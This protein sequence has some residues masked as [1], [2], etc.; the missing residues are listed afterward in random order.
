MEIKGFQEN[1]L[2]EWEG[3]LSCVLFL[4]YCNLR[5]RYCHAAHL[6]DPGEN[7]SIEREKILA[8][9]RRQEGWLDGAA[10][11]GGEPTLHGDE[12]RELIRQIR[13]TGLKVMLETNGSDPEMLD[14]LISD[15]LLDAM[16]MDVKAPLDRHSYQRVTRTEVDTD[17]LRASIQIIKNSGL[18]Y[19][20]RT[21]V[22][23]DLV[24][25]EELERIG[26]VLEGARAHALQN[27]QP[28]HCLDE[29]LHDWVPFSPE[30]MDRLGAIAR[31][32]VERV[33]IRGRDRGVIHAAEN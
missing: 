28:D 33:I 23:P 9:M 5:C 29:E 3:K 8:Y 14:D 21:T 22:V 16:S 6:L 25:A 20:F 4:P 10:I 19:E 15:G 18:E 13:D 31:P 11:T 24:G 17:A 7:E 30:D 12:L 27:F 32:Y 2:L 1:S 26:P